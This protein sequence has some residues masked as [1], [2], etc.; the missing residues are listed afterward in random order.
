MGEVSS[1]LGEA[2]V[3]RN[4]G[5]VLANNQLGMG[6]AFGQQETEAL[7]PT[8]HKDLNPTNNHLSKLESGS[9]SH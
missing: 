1:P 7:G 2:Y 4:L 8:T 5:Q 6:K 3:A 9:F